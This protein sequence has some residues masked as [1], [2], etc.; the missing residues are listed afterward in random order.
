MAR[1]PADGSRRGRS[2]LLHTPDFEIVLLVVVAGDEGVL[3][4]AFRVDVLLGDLEW[5]L[6]EPARQFAVKRAIE[7]ID[8]LPR[9]QLDWLAD[10]HHLILIALADTI[11]GGTIPIGADQFRLTGIDS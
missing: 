10:R 9:L 7:F 6:H 8:R 2:K 3:V 4:A 5:R 11:V 1:S